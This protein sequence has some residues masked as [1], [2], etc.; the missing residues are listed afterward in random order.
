MEVSEMEVRTMQMSGMKIRE[1]NGK[2]RLEGYF[3]VFDQPYE[4]CP[5]WVESIAPGAFARAL[6]SGQ[7]VKVLWNHN[8]DIVLGS[9]GNKTADLREDQRG[10]PGGVEINEQDQDAKNAYARV[11]RGDVNGCSFGFEISKMEESWDDDG[12]YRTRILEVYPL[13][14]VSPCTFP[15]YTQTSVTARAKEELQTAHERL[16]KAKKEKR[17]QWREKM[18]SR[19]KGEKDGT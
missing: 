6:A 14:E 2:R 9:T 17:E 12:T 15:A 11:D 3:A 5:G 10:L 13:F 18:L 16:E 8:P 4:V 1:E 7:D 19:L